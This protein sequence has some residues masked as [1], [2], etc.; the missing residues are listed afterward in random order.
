MS[1]TLGIMHLTNAP[2]VHILAGRHMNKMDALTLVQIM[3]RFPDDDAARAYFE[4]LRWPEGAACVHCGSAEV[5][6]LTPKAGSKRPGRKGLYSCKYCKRQYTVTV[7]TVMEDSHIPLRKWL[8]GFFL[9][10]SSKK[11]MSAHQLHRMLKLNYRSAWFM[12]HRIRH[13]MHQPTVREKLFGVIEVDET[14]V[15][16]KVRPGSFLRAEEQTGQRPAWS[17]GKM[18]VVT[19]VQRN[20]EARSFHVR[21]VTENNIREVLRRHVHDGS[22]IVTDEA[23]VYE[24]L[25][26]EFGSHETVNHG[27]KEYSRPGN[28][29]TN[30]VESY[31]A[32]LEARR[33]RNVSSR[34]REAPAPLPQRIRFQV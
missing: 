18:P 31:F 25:S 29:T 16:G 13:A 2:K 15:G 17:T 14:Y 24:N 3:D 21:R 6:R 12:A 27:A 23:K 7:H 9:M 11:G 20:G 33:D 4:K 32:L 10:C 22:A 19:L 5:Y 34:Q 8:L 26:D 1:K 28:V 30:T